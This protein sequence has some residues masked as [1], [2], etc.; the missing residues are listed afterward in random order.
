MLKAALGTDGTYNIPREQADGLRSQK[1]DLLSNRET[2]LQQIAYTN[3]HAPYDG[4]ITWSAQHGAG[5]FKMGDPLFKEINGTVFLGDPYNNARNYAILFPKEWNIRSGDPVLV[6]TP[7]GMRLM[8][9]VADVNKGP[10]SSTIQLGQVQSVEVKVF[11]PQNSLRSGLPVQ[12]IMPTDREKEYLKQAMA[13]AVRAMAS[14]PRAAGAPPPPRGRAR[15][16]ADNAM[17]TITRR[18]FLGYLTASIVAAV[19]RPLTAQTL[20]NTVNPP[21]PYSPPQWETLNIAQIYKMVVGNDLTAGPEA[22]QV[23]E[24]KAKERLPKA[25][26]MSLT[27]D[28]WREGNGKLYYAGGLQGVLGD[29]VGG[30]TTGNAIA[31]GLPII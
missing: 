28:V 18:G 4:I 23:L 12:I 31:A 26:Q 6:Q 8:G 1:N 24:D 25:N 29:V 13:S 19:A 20:Q 27:G 7:D 16:H 2:L 15:A 11:D 22:I 3:I 10:H 21:Q 9:Q 30:L 17:I 5:V 14:Q